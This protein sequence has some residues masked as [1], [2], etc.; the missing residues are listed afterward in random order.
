M[1]KRMF[2]PRRQRVSWL[3]QRSPSRPC[4]RATPSGCF[5]AAKAE[6]SRATFQRRTT[7]RN[8]V[9]KMEGLQDGIQRPAKKAA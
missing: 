8:A 7:G 4:R 1:L 2:L 9:A 5:K 6:D 3:V